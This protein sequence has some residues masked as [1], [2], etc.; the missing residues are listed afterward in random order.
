MHF[1]KIRIFFFFLL[2]LLKKSLLFIKKKEKLNK[3]GKM[4]RGA[5]KLFNKNIFFCMFFICFS[6]FGFGKEAI[7]VVAV[8]SSPQPD[9][10]E[11]TIVFPKEGEIEKTQTSLVEIRMRGFPIGTM[12][13]LPRRDDIAVSEKGQTIHVVVDNHPYFMVCGPSVDPFEQKGNYYEADFRIKI[14]FSLEKGLHILRAFPARAFGESL[15]GEKVFQTMYFYVK[16]KDKIPSFLNQPYIT[17]N[18]P[19]GQ[20]PLKEG[21]P[22]LLDF[23]VSNAT[24]TPDG[25]KV[26][27]TIDNKE[28]RYLTEWAPYYIYGLKKGQHKVHLQLLDAKNLPVKDVFNNVISQFIVE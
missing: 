21:Q 14:P 10:A 1:L 6:S 13:S 4:T 11:L 20:I 28:I 5:M 17:Y 24:I 16:E 26:K 19:S 7:Q 27:L 2:P 3:K 18:E 22:I 8:K 25:Y 15:K 23:Y 9:E 12:S